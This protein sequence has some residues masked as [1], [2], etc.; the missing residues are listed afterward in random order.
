MYQ[1]FCERTGNTAFKQKWTKIAI[2]ESTHIVNLVIEKL[3]VF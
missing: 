1:K 3:V 2:K